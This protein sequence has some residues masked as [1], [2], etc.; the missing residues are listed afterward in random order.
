MHYWGVWHG[1]ELFEAFR[2]HYYRF[3]SEFGFIAYP[4]MDTIE[5][6]T[7]PQDRNALSYVMESHQKCKYGNG[8]LIHYLTYYLRYP[9]SL[10]LLVYAT[11]YLQGEC[12]R[13]AVEHFRRH[14]GRCMGTTYWQV[15]DCWPTASWASI[16]SF[17]RWKGLHYFAK[18]FYAPVHLSAHED[19][20]QVTLSLQN[21]TLQGFEGTVKYRLMKHDFTTLKSGSLKVSSPRMSAQDIITLD[22]SEELGTEGI[23]ARTVAMNVWDTESTAPALRDTVLAFELYAKDGTLLEA[24]STLFCKAKHFDFLKPKYRVSVQEQPDRFLI[25]VGSNVYAKG[26]EVDVKGLQFILSDN[27]FDLTSRKAVTLTLLKSDMDKEMSAED[28]KKALTFQSLY[29]V[30]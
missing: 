23:P 6:F 9:N 15:N 17:G 12:I 10:P 20:T 3:C 7:L 1:N 5:S 30:Q 13:I 24:S 2:T 16:D 19:R 4:H 8:K 22:F 11:Q 25:T 18:R 27:F 29:D 26:V 21:E 28:I 14:R